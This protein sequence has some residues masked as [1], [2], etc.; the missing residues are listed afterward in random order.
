MID[1]STHM[2]GEHRPDLWGQGYVCQVHRPIAHP[3]QVHR[4]EPDP[5]WGVR[6]GIWNGER[7]MSRTIFVDWKK[8]FTFSLVALAMR[9]YPKGEGVFQRDRVFGAKAL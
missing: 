1:Y 7:T 3:A 8:Y 4:H 5:D 6:D 9:E 2:V